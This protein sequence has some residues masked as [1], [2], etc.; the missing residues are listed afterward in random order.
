M[1]KDFSNKILEEIE[2]QPPTT[3]KTVPDQN[4]GDYEKNPTLTTK[5][6]IKDLPVD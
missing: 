2:L 3:S 1:E 5:T 6:R 4:L